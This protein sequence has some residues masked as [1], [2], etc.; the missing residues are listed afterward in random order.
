MFLAQAIAEFGEELDTDSDPLFMYLA[1]QAVHVPHNRP[2]SS[3]YDGN[4]PAH[5]HIWGSVW[6]YANVFRSSIFSF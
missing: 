4:L 6:G 1:F 3:L 2:P 5:P